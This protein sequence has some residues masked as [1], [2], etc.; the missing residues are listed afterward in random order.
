[1]VSSIVQ[2]FKLYYFDCR[3]K[4]EVLEAGLLR[5]LMQIKLNMKR[6]VEVIRSTELAKKDLMTTHEEIKANIR[7]TTAFLETNKLG[8]DELRKAVKKQKESEVLAGVVKKIPDPKVTKARIDQCMKE[9][10]E[11]KVRVT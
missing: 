6:T 2:I 5:Q 11:L 3:T 9:L 1:M 7:T 10:E 4:Q 8:D